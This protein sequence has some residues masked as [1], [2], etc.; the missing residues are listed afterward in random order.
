MKLDLSE[1]AQNV[2]KRLTYQV[3]ELYGEVW[4]EIRLLDRITGTVEF[5]N[6]GRL[7]LARGRVEAHVEVEC[8]RCLTRFGV[9]VEALIEE[10]FPIPNYQGGLAQE[11]EEEEPVPVED[12]LLFVDNVLDFSELIRQSL[13]VAMP[14]RPLCEETCKG[15]CVRCGKNLNEGPCGCPEVIDTPLA[16]LAELLEPD[17]GGEGGG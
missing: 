9:P 12:E 1:I 7:V 2:G 4:E 16:G 10:Q 11:E 17:E 15:L 6:T 13:V 8:S 14:I 3:D 5:S